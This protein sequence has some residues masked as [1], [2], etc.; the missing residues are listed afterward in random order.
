MAVEHHGLLHFE[1]LVVVD[2]GDGAFHAV[3]NALLEGHVEFR[4]RD[5]GGG[6]A[7]AAGH[8]HVGGVFH[9]AH[10]EALHVGGGLHFRGVGGEVAEAV[11]GNGEDA[12]A[13]ALEELVGKLL[14]EVGLEEFPAGGIAADEVGNV[15]GHGLGEEVGSGAAGEGAHFDGAHLDAFEGFGFTAK[16]AGVVEHEFHFAVGGLLHHVSVDVGGADGAVFKGVGAGVGHLEGDLGFGG[17]G[18]GE[19]DGHGK[20]SGKGLFQSCILGAERGVGERIQNVTKIT[21][22]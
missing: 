16:L 19:Q 5:G 10:L 13:G 9:H 18:A 4:V 15:E 2:V 7:E 20:E 12:H 8:G 22:V 17:S 1:E 14:H 3:H 6:S 11:F 21:S